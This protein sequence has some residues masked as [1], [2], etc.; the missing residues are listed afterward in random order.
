MN[1]F[2]NRRI[3]LKAHFNENPV[4]LLLDSSA[5]FDVISKQF[6]LNN[7]KFIR[8]T[9]LF[10]TENIDETILRKDNDWI[11]YQTKSLS[12]R[13]EEK[14]IATQLWVTDISKL[15]TLSAKWLYDQIS[16]IDW[17]EEQ[18]RFRDRKQ[19]DWIRKTLWVSWN[20]HELAAIETLS[21]KYDEFRVIF[22]EK[23]ELDA[24]SEHKSWD[25]E[26]SLEEGKILF[27]DCTYEL[28]EEEQNE[29]KKY[30][31][32]NLDK[33]FIR[34]STSFADHL[35]L[36]AKKQDEELRLCVNYRKLNDITIKNRYSLS[37]MKE[38]KIKLARA[39][40]FTKLDLKNAFHQIRMKKEKKWKTVFR[41]RQRLF[42]YQMMSFELANASIT[43]QSVIN[44]VLEEYLDDFAMTYLNDILIYFETTEKHK[45]DTI[46]VLQ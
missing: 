28:F 36:F 12:L 31:K 13:I 10:Q 1:T 43:F 46:R 42:E 3:F 7:N 5:S 40:W 2:K 25:C 22:E 8:K 23:I 35:I 4:I 37:L 44:T 6:V 29:L 21:K 19:R 15:L 24:L 41:T 45:R 11:Q 14:T 38:I 30:L 18:M 16:E 27:K 20:S 33:Q 17:T 26:I 34:H 9:R 32:K 39:N